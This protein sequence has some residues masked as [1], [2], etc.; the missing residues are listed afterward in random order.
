MPRKPGRNHK[1][2][3][4]ETLWGIHAQDLAVE[5]GVTV[6][7]IHM[8]VYLWGTPW[9]RASKPTKYEKEWGRTLRELSLEYNMSPYT[10]V[11]RCK[12]G[13][14]LDVCKQE[15]KSRHPDPENW[16]SITKRGFWLHPNHPQYTRARAGNLTDDD[17]REIQNVR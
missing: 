15:N 11:H 2:S 14:P 6:D 13:V 10:V 3:Q 16:P 17:V 9:R 12:T 8:R 7:A 4:F 1:M 5:E